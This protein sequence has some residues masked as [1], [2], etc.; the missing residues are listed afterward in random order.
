MRL[1][2]A[3]AAYKP[4]WIEEPICPEHVGGYARIK[5]E[6]GAP[7]AGGEHLYTRWP[8]KAFL[9]RKCVDY[10]QSDPIWCGGISEWLRV[11]DLVRGYPG[12]KMVPHITSPWLAAPHCVA[13]QPEELCPLLEFNYEG[14]RKSLEVRM[15]KRSDGCMVMAMPEAPGLS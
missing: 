14:G 15:T 2:K 9:D 10:V 11:C 12:V 8:V 4:F 13:S 3:V 5:G 7:I 6:T 1:C